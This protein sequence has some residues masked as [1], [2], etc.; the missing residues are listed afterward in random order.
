MKLAKLATAYVQNNPHV[1]KALN[2][3]L[4]N[5][6]AVSRKIMA[7]HRISEKNAKDALII[8]LRRLKAQKAKEGKTNV[9][10]PE[11]S[12]KEFRGMSLVVFSR[13]VLA[14]N[15]FALEAEF[16]DRSLPFFILKGLNGTTV[17]CGRKLYGMFSDAVPDALSFSM[18]NCNVKVL[19]FLE[20]FEKNGSL[21]T[22]LR[23]VPFPH[24]K[25]NVFVFQN[26]IVIVEE[27]K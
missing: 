23:G 12:E 8:A 4:L 19:S 3:G 10:K 15:I 9:G 25:G 22:A 18:E 21:G 5:Y 11:F 26:H 13:D 1:D 20:N 14:K 24:G 2:E 17:V 6:S 16:N 7:T 27:E